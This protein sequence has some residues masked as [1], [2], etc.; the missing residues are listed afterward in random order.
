M[1]YGGHHFLEQTIDAVTAAIGSDRVGIKLQQG[2]TFS[3]LVEPED[4]SLAQLA[5]LGPELEKRNIAFVEMSSLNYAPYYGYD[6]N[7]C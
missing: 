6:G 3:G 5:Y 1:A 2:V 4:D 7:T